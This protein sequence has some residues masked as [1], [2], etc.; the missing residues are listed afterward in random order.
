MK[1]L[2]VKAV[3]ILL[4]LGFAIWSGKAWAAEWKEFVEATTGVFDYDAADISSPS[5]GFVR[6]WIH[7]VTKKETSHVE[8]N[9]KDRTYRVLDVIQYDEARRI[10]SRDTYYNHP[11]PTWYSIA[12]KSV[13]EPL[14]SIVCP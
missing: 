10:K 1:S 3:I 9:C 7:N 6:V 12:P 5:K 4:A 8:I 14:Q 11:A 2:S 13:V